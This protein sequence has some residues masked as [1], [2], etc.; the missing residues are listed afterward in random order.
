MLKV[1]QCG[2][3]CTI[4]ALFSAAEKSREMIKRPKDNNQMN[5]SSK[6][7]KRGKGMNK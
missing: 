3:F 6:K 4:A 1:R 5:E 2:S 7:K